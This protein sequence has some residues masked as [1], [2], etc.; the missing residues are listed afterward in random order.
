M[1]WIT[2]LKQAIEYMEEHLPDDI[3][4]DDVA[5]A[6]HMSPFYLQKGFQI[7]T[8]YSL[9]EYIRNRRL[10][11]A[12]L[13][14]ISGKAKIIDIALQYGYETPESF[15][16][17]FSRFHGV[18]PTQIRKSKDAI[19]TFLPLTISITVQGGNKMDYSVE[20]MNSFKIIGYQKEF[21]Y[22]TAYAE[23]P[24]FWDEITSQKIF[25]LSGKSALETL[26]EKTIRNCRIGEFGVCIDDIGKEGKFRYL[27]AGTYTDGDIPEGMTV[28]EFPDLEWAKF[29]CV[30]PMPGAIQS[31]NTK[32]FKEWLPGN[33]EFEVAM[34]A[35]IEWYSAGKN[36]TDIDYESGI[37]LPVK[38]K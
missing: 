28:Y 32:I 12:A 20:K 24:K 22:H 1:E 8:G 38:R 37:W 18:T 4:A 36:M 2:S 9:S 5:D 7:I 25:P 19:R 35:N 10:Y 26:E 33:A 16:K 11:L 23:I 27:I 21:E 14:I 17:A 30:G 29:K 6:V 34:D 15:T 31:V 3:G 13:D